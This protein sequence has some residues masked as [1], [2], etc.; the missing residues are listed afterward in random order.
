MLVDRWTH[1]EPKRV[2]DARELEAAIIKLQAKG[3]L[4]DADGRKLLS[5]AR[6]IIANG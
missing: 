5:D 1:A 2:R 6:D 3:L 4:Q